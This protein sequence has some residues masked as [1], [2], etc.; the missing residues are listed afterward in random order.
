MALK[1]IKHA[2]VR[3]R[4]SDDDAEIIDMLNRAIRGTNEAMKVAERNRVAIP[5]RD[6]SLAARLVFARLSYQITKEK[7]D[8]VITIDQR[9]NVVDDEQS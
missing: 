2:G 7:L 5:F 6:R 3:V 4:V 1:A 9:G 8:D